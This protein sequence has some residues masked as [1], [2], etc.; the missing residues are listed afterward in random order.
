MLNFADK[1]KALDPVMKPLLSKYDTDETAPIFELRDL[2]ISKLVGADILRTQL[3]KNRYVA[4]HA[5]NRGAEGLIPAHAFELISGF[6]GGGLSLS[7][8]CIPIVVEMPSSSHPDYLPLLEFVHKVCRDSGGAVPPY[9]DDEV[10]YLINCTQNAHL[11][12]FALH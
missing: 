9:A 2:A 4:F 5:R 1:I 8:V 6:T 3:I 7:E 12:S 10:K 11:P